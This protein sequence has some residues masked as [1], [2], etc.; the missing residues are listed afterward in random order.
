M[1]SRTNV[2]LIVAGCL[3]LSVAGGC[4]SKDQQMMAADKKAQD[5]RMM[6]DRGMRAGDE[7]MRMK[8]ERMME[9]GQ[10]MKDKG[11]QMPASGGGGMAMS[12]SMEQRLQGWPESS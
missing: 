6:R 1:R 7:R 10:M 8:G 9:E 12:G 5:G 4:A 2:T 3:A 11:M